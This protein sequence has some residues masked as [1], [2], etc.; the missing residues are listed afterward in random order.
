MS[1]S[2]VSNW[3]IVVATICWYSTY[4]TSV[5]MRWNAQVPWRGGRR[6]G[7]GLRSAD[8]YRVPSRAIPPT[9]YCRREGVS[10][11]GGRDFFGTGFGRPPVTR[12][13]CHQ[14]PMHAEPWEN[15]LP[16]EWMWDWLRMTRSRPPGRAG[17]DPSRAAL[18]RAA[19]QQFEELCRA[20]EVSGPAS[21]PLPLFYALSQAGRAITAARGGPEHRAHGLTLGEPAGDPLETQLRPHVRGREPGQFQAVAQ[22]V[23]SAAIGEPVEIG[24]LI[25]ALPEM[26]NPLLIHEQWPQ[27]LPIWLRTDEGAVP[28]PGYTSIVIGTGENEFTLQELEQ[29]LESY[30]SARRRIGVPDVVRTFPHLPIYHTPSGLGV[31]VLFHGD[32]RDLDA[33]VPQYRIQDWRWLR[34]SIAG[35]DAPSPL[36]NWWLLLFALSMYARYWPKQWVSALDVDSSVAAVTL[37][38]AM[39]RGVKAL[40]QLVLNEVLAT[41]ILHPSD[42]GPSLDPFG[43]TL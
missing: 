36:M 4:R 8:R 28:T 37:E 34:P 1:A 14:Q 12:N 19:L 31:G 6:P 7:I 3:R 38:R 22:A 32:P 17:S 40:P 24:A 13:S 5:P 10:L 9:R 18:Y 29:L 27:A 23:D 33:L 35:K 42:V 11:A 41:P 2:S 25:A 21:R 16:M 43:H 39:T 26:A 30:P 15:G 20:A